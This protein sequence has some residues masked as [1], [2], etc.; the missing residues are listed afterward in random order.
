MN[1]R[2]PNQWDPKEVIG[3]TG[4]DYSKRKEAY[5]ITE[6]EFHIGQSYDD[7]GAATIICKNCLGRDFNVG[8]GSHYTAIRCVVCEWEICIHSG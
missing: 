6:E 8:I 3:G 7:Y 4:I 5:L 2:K 1:E